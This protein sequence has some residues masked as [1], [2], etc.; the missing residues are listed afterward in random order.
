MSQDTSV[1]VWTCEHFIV[2]SSARLDCC[3]TAVDDQ[4]NHCKEK[5]IKIYVIFTLCIFVCEPAYTNK[6]RRLFQQFWYHSTI[7]AIVLGG[8]FQSFLKFLQSNFLFVTNFIDLYNC[9]RSFWHSFHLFEH[10]FKMF[11]INLVGFDLGLCIAWANHQIFWG[12]YA[13]T[14][15][16]KWYTNMVHEYDTNG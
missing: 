2:V 13:I 6:Q 16:W 14:I 1:C 3:C 4:K 7:L 12:V 10:R 5:Q 8:L 11:D 15:G 9:F